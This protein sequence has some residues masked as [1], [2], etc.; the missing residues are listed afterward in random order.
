MSLNLEKFK[1]SFSFSDFLLPSLQQLLHW[2]LVGFFFFL[3]FFLIQIAFQC[4]I[5]LLL[6][7][8]RPLIIEFFKKKYSFPDFFFRHLCSYCIE[9]WFIVLL[10]R[11]TVPVR[12]LLLYLLFNKT[13]WRIVTLMLLL[14]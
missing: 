14:F 9:T 11:V 10:Y 1:E 7:E 4:Q 12:V 8:L 6:Q 2:N 3:S 13:G 5:E